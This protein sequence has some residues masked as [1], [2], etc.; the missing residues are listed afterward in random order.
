MRVDKFSPISHEKFK[1]EALKNHDI[2][3]AYQELEDEF[4]LIA[5]MIKTRKMAKK[6]QQDV[7]KEMHTSQ[8]VVARIE[9]GFSYQK[10]SP[11]FNTLKKYAKALGCHLLIKLV[12]ERTREE[13][14][15]K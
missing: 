9:N 14:D 8:T 4:A 11:T 7:A 13:F 2:N 10:H 12:P 15:F 5:E 3:Q 6:T 1:K